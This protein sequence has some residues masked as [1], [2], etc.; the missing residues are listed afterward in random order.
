MTKE[1]HTTKESVAS[2]PL[3]IVGII[4]LLLILIGVAIQLYIDY[5]SINYGYSGPEYLTEDTLYD[6]AQKDLDDAANQAD[7]AIVDSEQ[8]QDLK[9]ETETEN[10]Q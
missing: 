10:A 6:D 1:K 2:R 9:P 7:D 3:V 5:D 4:T 8:E